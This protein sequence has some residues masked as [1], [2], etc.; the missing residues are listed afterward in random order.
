MSE[1][2]VRGDVVRK[3]GKMKLSLN[4]IYLFMVSYNTFTIN[5]FH[6]SRWQFC[7]CIAASSQLWNG[8]GRRNGWL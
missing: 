6:V 1:T 7:L 3:R 2:L 5:S 4:G 8:L